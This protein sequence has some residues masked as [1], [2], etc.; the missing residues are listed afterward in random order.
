MAVMDFCVRQH[1]RVWAKVPGLDQKSSVDFTRVARMGLA[2]EFIARLKPIAPLLHRRLKRAELMRRPFYRK[3]GYSL[4]VSVFELDLRVFISHELGVLFN[5]I[6]KAGHSSVVL[7]LTK[8]QYGRD[9]EI[10]TAKKHA[11]A[12]PSSLDREAVE[13]LDGYFKFTLVRN[14]YTRTLSAYLDKVVRGKVVPKPLA[15]ST[16]GRAPSFLDFCLY[17]EDGG[18]ND[19]LHWAPQTAQMVIPVS[20]FDKIARLENF[21]EDFGFVLEQI[22]LGERFQDFAI[23]KYDSHKT[24]SDQKRDEYYCSRSR[25]IIARLMA[26]DFRLLGYPAD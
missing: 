10:G 19:A 12:K 25:E 1:T 9:F 17:L 5:G 6:G 14:P 16:G 18:L 23:G 4:P 7:N 3:Y 2:S 13:R 21:N 24:Q 11:F 8:A 22:G 26:D 20:D 15:R